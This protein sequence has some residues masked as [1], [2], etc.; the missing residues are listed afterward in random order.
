LKEELL[1]Y[2]QTAFLFVG[3][4]PPPAPGPEVFAGLNSPGARRTANTYKAFS[5][6]GIGGYPI[7]FNE[8][9]CLFLCPMQQRVKFENTM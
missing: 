4:F 7:L 1:V 9:V 2:V 5:V 8:V 3:I 6:Q